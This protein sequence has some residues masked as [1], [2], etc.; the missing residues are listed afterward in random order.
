[1]PLQ[2]LP[3]LTAG[4]KATGGSG[5]NGNVNQH[6]MPP[7]QMLTT[8]TSSNMMMGGPGV[9]QQ[10]TTLMTMM[11][12]GRVQAT[13]VNGAG[14]VT[15]QMLSGPA[16]AG[17]FVPMQPPMPMMVPM[18]WWGPPGRKLAQW[19]GGGYSGYSGRPGY[20][21]IWGSVPYST[22]WPSTMGGGMSQSQ[23]Q[24]WLPKSW[25]NF[26]VLH[27]MFPPVL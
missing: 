14:K 15:T 26:L 23:A 17:A 24:V 7:Q 1:M 21:S 20:S 18:Q 12:D 10:A 2:P 22:S 13:T 4:V 6:A 9:Q 5:N 25:R 19:W 3:G 27:C 8:T 16:A 11:P